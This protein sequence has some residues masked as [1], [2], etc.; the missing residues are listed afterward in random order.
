MPKKRNRPKIKPKNRAKARGNFGLWLKNYSPKILKIFAF[1]FL[2]FYFAYHL[3]N[4]SNGM[5]NYFKQ[6]KKLE[7]LQIELS[8]TEQKRENLQKKT[9][10]LY[11]NSLDP[12]LLDEQYRR[13]S[14]KIKPTEAIYYYD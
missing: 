14:G 1:T 4:G 6:Q 13:S 3:I 7:K 9:K 8:T 5:I 12:D 10:K 2:F 11:Q